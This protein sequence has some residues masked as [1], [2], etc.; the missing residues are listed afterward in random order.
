M[1]KVSKSEI[2]EAVQAAITGVLDKL[3]IRKPSKKTKKTIGKISKQIK[4]DL[5][6]AAKKNRKAAKAHTRNGK[7]HAKAA[8]ATA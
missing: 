6:K 3:E 1:K 7:A 4:G 2:K 8:A 5:R